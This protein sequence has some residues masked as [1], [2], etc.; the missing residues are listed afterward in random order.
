MFCDSPLPERRSLFTPSW[1]L[2]PVE[3]VWQFMRDNRLSNRI[4]Q[5]Y[6]DIV[7]HRCFAWNKLVE[8]PWRTMSLGLRQ[9]AH[10]F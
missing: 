6:D 1:D 4:F 8:Q 5:S 7:D 10:G 2:N 3:T 9:W